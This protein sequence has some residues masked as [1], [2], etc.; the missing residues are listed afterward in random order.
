M[1]PP[2]HSVDTPEPPPRARRRLVSLLV[3]LG[4]AI[5]LLAHVGR[6]FQPY[7]FLHGDG[8]FYATIN[9]ALLEGT[10]E[11]HAFHPASWYEEDLGWNRDLDQGWSNIALGADGEWYPKHPFLMPAVATPFFWIAGY[12]GLLA[13][14]VLMTVLALWLAWRIARRWARPE[15]AAVITVAAAT[16]PLFTL[17]AYSYSNDVFYAALVL[18]GL[19]RFLA[20][21]FG[22]SGVLLGLA[23][24]A[25]PTNAIFGLPLG[26]WL[27]WQ[28]RWRDAAWLAGAAAVPAAAWLVSNAVMFGSP[29]TTSY[30][31]ILVRE[32]G[33]PMLES[34]RDRFGR[35][36]LPGV[37]DLVRERGGL[38]DSAHLLLLGLLGVPWLGRRAGWRVVG[39]G[40]FWLLAYALFYGPYEYRY[41]RF[42][43][44]WAGL[45]ITPLAVGVDAALGALA[46]ALS[47]LRRP[48]A[49]R[50]ALVVAAA[51]V[52]ALGLRLAVA[53]SGPTWRAV[54]AVEEARV[55]RETGAGVLACDYFNPNHQKFECARVESEPWMYWGRALGDE[56][57]LDGQVRD[58]LWL[59][60]L[61]GT[62]KRITFPDVPEGPL[63]LRHG[64]SDR[65]RARGA[66]FRLLDGDRVL[67]TLR[68][69]GPGEI[70]TLTV[71]AD[72]RGDGPLIL[73]I[74]KQPHAWRQ[75]CVDLAVP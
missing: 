58:W 39:V 42:F 37:L 1:P 41:A 36:L 29:L 63:R 55:E 48:A 23:I 30:D 9:R 56:C 17:T 27:L 25:K 66:R 13:F 71:P 26:A 4:V 6:E 16:L 54:D 51:V 67:A 5:V 59:H 10:L 8:A 69:G 60:L 14:D 28:R 45:L 18:G 43:L 52:V 57:V 32:D 19:D 65:S 68:T 70:G 38:W 7:T 24:W 44:P 3:L 33:Q 34:V 22:W 20:G 73:E 11:Q 49:R 2:M 74:P 35:D 53:T 12:A 21:R 75:L 72:D 40:A 61:P 62:T 46:F 64:L 15:V 31:R 50:V 47:R